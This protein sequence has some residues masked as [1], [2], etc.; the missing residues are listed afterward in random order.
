MTDLIR[1]NDATL[2]Q[3]V[4]KD[5]PVVTFQQIAEVHGVP[6]DTIRR[7]FQRNKNRLQEGEDYFRL[8]FT[9]ASQIGRS[10]ASNPNGEIVLTENGYLLLVKPMRD[11][12]SWQVQRQMRTAYFTLKSQQSHPMT[13][14]EMHL[15]QAKISVELERRQNAIEARQDVAEARM[16]AIEQR[17][18]PVGKFTVVSWVRYHGKPYLNDEMMRLLKRGCQHREQAAEFRPEG[19]DWIQRYYTPETIEAAY[20]DVTKQLT[21]FCRE[22]RTPYRLTKHQHHQ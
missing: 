9:E 12:V 19:T 1:I 6:I 10:V 17:R 8:D 14:A 4:Y 3:I 22:D 2:E 20:A 18:P 5:A 21:F 11:D 15:A 7:T 16:D 13:N